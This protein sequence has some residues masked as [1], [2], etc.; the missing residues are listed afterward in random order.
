MISGKGVFDIG[1]FFYEL[2]TSQTPYETFKFILTKSYFN[3]IKN[4]CNKITKEFVENIL[5]SS[6]YEYPEEKIFETQNIK[7]HDFFIFIHEQASKECEN[8]DFNYIKNHIQLE[9]E[10]ELYYNKDNQNIKGLKE[11]LDSNLFKERKKLILKNLYQKKLAELIYKREFNP[12]IEP[13]FKDGYGNLESLYRDIK[14]VGNF[15]I[16]GDKGQGKTVIAEKILE[17]K[18]FEKQYFIKFDDIDFSLQTPRGRIDKLK[19]IIKDEIGLDSSTFLDLEGLIIFDSV[20]KIDNLSNFIDILKHE[21]FNNIAT[22]TFVPNF[23][24]IKNI[25]DYDSYEIRVVE[26]PNIKNFAYT[27][28]KSKNE[29]KKLTTEI[30]SKMKYIAFK[31]YIKESIK[32]SEKVDFYSNFYITEEFLNYISGLYVFELFEDFDNKK[33]GIQEFFSEKN[34]LK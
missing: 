25:V 11:Y 28:E 24:E 3:L 8:L 23:D 4:K 31:Q 34:I 30:Q 19:E 15:F 32:I 21:Q 22:V 10:T 13:T 6:K 1:K 26:N 29:F 14:E 16:L 17:Q 7:D 2:Q 18:L 20:T 33:E 5:K 27:I 12:F 9:V